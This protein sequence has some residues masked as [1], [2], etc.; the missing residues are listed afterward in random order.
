MAAKKEIIKVIRCAI[1]KFKYFIKNELIFWLMRP[2]K[3]YYIIRR[4]EPGAGFFSNYFWVLGHIVFARKIGYVPIVDMQNYK[5]LYSE[6]V[7]VLGERNAWNYYFEDV[8]SICLGEALNSKKYIYSKEK[9]LAKYCEK[10]ASI[11]YRYPTEEMINYYAPIIAKYMRIKPDIVRKFQEDWRQK[12]IEGQDILGVH[13]RGTD[14]KNN[15]GHPMPATA[16]RYIEI[17]KNILSENSQI[18]MIFLASDEIEVIK[19]YMK[20]LEGTHYKLIV[21]D[22]FRADKSSEKKLVGIHEMNIVNERSYHKYNLGLEVLN[23]AWCLAKCDYLLC[24]HSNI[25]NIAILWNNKKYKKII[26]L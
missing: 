22:A 12:I 5:T 21:N 16:A 18:T 19:S 26:C 3:K 1:T 25:T 7:P 17:T 6:D 8:D 14:M 9:Y 13:I 4:P 15:L 11:P 20:W 23:D 2:I 10:Y 24:G